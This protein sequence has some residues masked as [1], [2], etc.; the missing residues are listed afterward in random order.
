MIFVQFFSF[1][2][3]FIT[4][5]Q[6]FWSTEALFF[7]QFEFEFGTWILSKFAKHENLEMK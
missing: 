7:F 3:S 6:S 2:I 4:V 1:A 5:L